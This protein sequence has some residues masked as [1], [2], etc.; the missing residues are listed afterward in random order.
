MSFDNLGE[1]I[2]TVRDDFKTPNLHS[3]LGDGL[4]SVFCENFRKNQQEKELILF[5][6]FEDQYYFPLWFEFRSINNNLLFL[7]IEYGISDFETLKKV[8][9]SSLEKEEHYQAEIKALVYKTKI[10]PPHSILI[11]F[12]IAAEDMIYVEE[13]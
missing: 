11:N 8:L 3:Y 1:I 10:K 9:L 13:E 4:V 7:F 6:T 5:F 12:S 2:R